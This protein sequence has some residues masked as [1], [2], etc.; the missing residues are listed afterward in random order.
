MLSEFNL[1]TVPSFYSENRPVR[2][3]LEKVFSQMYDP[4]DK[5]LVLFPAEPKIGIK[6]IK[7]CFS[8]MLEE[9]ITKAII[10]VQTGMTPS[11]KKVSLV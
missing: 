3:E 11:A 1:C 4:D 7:L 9:N 5:M 2:S 6:T 8:R 10:V